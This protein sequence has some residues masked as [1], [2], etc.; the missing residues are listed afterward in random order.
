MYTS[1][2]PIHARWVPPYDGNL[3]ERF[4]EITNCDAKVRETLSGVPT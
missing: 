4:Q 3:T 1:F 2:Y